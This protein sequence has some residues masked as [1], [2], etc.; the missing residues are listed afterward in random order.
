MSIGKSIESCIV[1]VGCGNF[2]RCENGIFPLQEQDFTEKELL[3]LERASDVAISLSKPC[4]TYYHYG[5]HENELLSKSENWILKVPERK[6]CA[7]EFSLP[8]ELIAQ[9]LT[10]Y[11]RKNGYVIKKPNHA[12]P[13]SYIMANEKFG[14]I[15]SENSL[16][17]SYFENSYLGKLTPHSADNMMEDA[18]ERI[19]LRVYKSNDDSYEDFDLAI[20][21]EEVSFFDGK[22]EYR[23]IAA[24]LKYRLCVEL[25]P[26][27]PIKKYH[28]EF[29]N[30]KE[31]KVKIIF[32]AKPCLSDKK[33]RANEYVFEENK[34]VLI[35]SSIFEKR[36]FVG[37]GASPRKMSFCFDNAALISDGQ[38]F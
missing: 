20:C 37:V 21:A 2:L 30:P 15:L 29:E 35:V 32:A 19:L 36:F 14:T 12:I 1:Q 27:D 9:N 18:G 5:Q 26:I 8:E 24:S 13:F 3:L 10:G 6:I 7:L 25:F 31:K 16:G 22:A 17:F 33:L 38:N 34:G 4:E 28:V 11:F 23:G